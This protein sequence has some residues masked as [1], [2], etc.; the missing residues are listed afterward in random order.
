MKK[1][2]IK[3]H[4]KEAKKLGEMDQNGD[5]SDDEGKVKLEDEMVKR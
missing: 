4:K 1:S 5:H 2:E 3:K